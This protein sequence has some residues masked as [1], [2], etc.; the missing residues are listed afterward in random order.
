MFAPVFEKA[1]AQLADKY[2]LIKVDID[3]MPA[4]ASDYEVMSVPTL[5]HTSGGKVIKKRAG[6]F[7]TVDHIAKW[8]EG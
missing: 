5:V 8:V 2:T 4:L 7:P 6:A 3:Q 1:T